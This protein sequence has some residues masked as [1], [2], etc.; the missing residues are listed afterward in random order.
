[1]SSSPRLL[2]THP[3]IYAPGGAET[4]CLRTIEFLQDHYDDITLIHAG[5]PLDVD[6][7]VQWCGVRLDPAKVKFISIDL[8]NFLLRYSLVTYSFVQRA[9]QRIAKE[10]D[11]ILSIWGEVTVRHPR[12]FQY[13]QYPQYYY[14]WTSVIHLVSPTYTNP[15]KHA[16]RWA[17]I[18]AGRLISGWNHDVV[19]QH[20]TAVNSIWTGEQFR[21]EYGPCEVKPIYIGVEVGLKPGDTAFKPFADRDNNFVIIGRVVP[22]KRAHLAVEIVRRLR[23]ERGHDIGLHIIGRGTGA[24]AD[25]ITNLIA[26][27]PWANW[28]THFNRNEL[29]AFTASQKWGIHCNLFEPYGLAPLEL[30]NLGCIVFSADEAAQREIV[31]DIALRYQGT[32]DA[33]EKIDHVLRHPEEHAVWLARIQE[34][35]TLHNVARFNQTY[36]EEVRKLLAR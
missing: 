12:V 21:R 7:I 13:V 31:R 30:Q 16:M 11:L 17:N 23:E 28:H 2:F 1:M 27:K 24:Y 10:Y 33:V 8:P 35:L 32:E 20:V 34:W 18:M 4:H 29:E 25:H 14:S 36:L 6:R 22:L 19:M 9:A 5:G 26:D 15:F 3:N